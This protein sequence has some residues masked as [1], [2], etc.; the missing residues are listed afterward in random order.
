M[1]EGSGIRR[2]PLLFKQKP[3]KDSDEAEIQENPQKTSAGKVKQAGI[4]RREENTP[5]GSPQDGRP[6]EEKKKL[7]GSQVFRI[8]L[9]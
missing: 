1:V 2:A 6:E 7:T 4:R 3:T 5:M 9:G 8:K